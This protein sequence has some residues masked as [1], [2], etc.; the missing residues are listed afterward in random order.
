MASN[1][2]GF[3]QIFRSIVGNQINEK[4]TVLIKRFV[5][6]KAP[7]ASAFQGAGGQNS[8]ESRKLS[9]TTPVHLPAEQSSR[10]LSQ[11]RAGTSRTLLQHF[12]SRRAIKTLS[13]SNHED[14]VHLRQL[15]FTRNLADG[16]GGQLDL[17]FEVRMRG[18][19]A[20]Q[21]ATLLEE[22]LAERSALPPDDARSLVSGFREGLVKEF[23]V[24]EAQAAAMIADT[25]ATY[26]S[27]ETDLV[28]T[29]NF[30][31]GRAW[32]ACD[33][34]CGKGEQRRGQ[35]CPTDTNGEACDP[36]SAV[37]LN[38]TCSAYA[39]C[40]FTECPLKSEESMVGGFWVDH[41]G[42]YGIDGYVGGHS[43]DCR[44]YV[45][46]LRTKRWNKTNDHQCGRSDESCRSGM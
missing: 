6:T 11:S 40:G 26:L 18:G 2:E 31:A 24:P 22:N 34:V 35:F 3:E 19:D 30:F 4:D 27:K 43:S 37:A 42:G 44:H 29:K 32:G 10:S 16:D 8:Q 33:A 1:K 21:R 25:S 38:Q 28:V 46:D 14:V 9:R 23:K 36:D 39:G 45:E 7:P 5:I 13:A 12:S 20:A 17:E 41:E 15:Q